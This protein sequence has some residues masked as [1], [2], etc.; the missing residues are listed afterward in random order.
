MMLEDPGNCFSEVSLSHPAIISQSGPTTK[1]NA[2]AQ[3]EVA[4]PQLLPQ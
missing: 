4:D 1:N 3:Q 2:M